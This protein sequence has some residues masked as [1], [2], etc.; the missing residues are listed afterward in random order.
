MTVELSVPVS[1]TTKSSQY[2]SVNDPSNQ[3]HKKFLLSDTPGHGK[4]RHHAFERIVKP[5]NLRGIIF[6]VDAADLSNGSSGMSNESLRQTAEYLHDLLLLLQKQAA[7]TRTSKGPKEL[8]VLIAANKM[9]LFTAL[10]AP[11]V[12]NALESEIT[13]VRNAVSKG[14]LDSG[15]GMS[16]L[17]ANDEKEW[18]GDGGEG[19]FEFSHM[20]ESNVYVDVAG[21]NVLGSD[22]PDVKQWWDWIG[23]NL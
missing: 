13:N 2:R 3:T 11:L 15:I 21:G 22:V 4:L 8:P 1:T 20:R 7:N 10:P 17:D 6:A 9:D 12:K 19:N 23:S 14:L 18:L 5:K 16:D